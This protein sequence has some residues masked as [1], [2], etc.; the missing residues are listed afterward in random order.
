MNAPRLTFCSHAL[1]AV[2]YLCLDAMV[3]KR[4]FADAMSESMVENKRRCAWRQPPSS[5]SCHSGSVLA[6]ELTFVQESPT[7]RL[8]LAWARCDAAQKIVYVKDRLL[9]AEHGASM[10]VLTEFF[11]DVCEIQGGTLVAHNLL[12]KSAAMTAELRRL[13]LTTVEDR[14]RTALERTCLCLESDEI[15][16]WLG[17]PSANRCMSMAD[18]CQ[19]LKIIFEPETTTRDGALLCLEVFL[20]LQKLALPP[21]QR[22]DTPHEFVP[23]DYCC[24]RDNG[25]RP[26]ATCRLCGATS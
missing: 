16:A 14:L 8:G 13:G 4:L 26:N 2:P 9:G 20:R 12:R 17:A 1:A 23:S 18:L 21:C 6:F 10:D 22:G 3:G 15:G 25:E 19:Q 7:V 24:V 11:A 5:L